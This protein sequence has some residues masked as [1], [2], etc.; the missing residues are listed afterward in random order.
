MWETLPSQESAPSCDPALAW[1]S[2]Q[3][4]LLIV[5]ALRGL[6]GPPGEAQPMVAA[7]R[8]GPGPPRDLPQSQAGWLATWCSQP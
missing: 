6:Q 4:R 3:G 7:S 1:E 2:A 8:G 5:S